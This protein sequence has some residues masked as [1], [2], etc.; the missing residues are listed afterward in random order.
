M[1]RDKLSME[2][3]KKRDRICK[4][5]EEEGVTERA[6]QKT[7]LEDL[8]Q[9]IYETPVQTQIKLVSDDT[10]SKTFKLPHAGFEN[11]TQAILSGLLVPEE[12]ST[13]VGQVT[14][15]ADFFYRPGRGNCRVFLSRC[16]SGIFGSHT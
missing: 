6:Q 1:S 10:A 8:K 12:L 11:S 7:T 9:A 13:N 5:F 14:P 2:R 15:V 16:S 4:S 3:K